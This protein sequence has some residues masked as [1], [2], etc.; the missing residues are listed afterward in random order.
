LANIERASAH[1]STTN[2]CE[3]DQFFALGVLL[4]KRVRSAWMTDVLFPSL[5]FPFVEF[6]RKYVRPA[7]VKRDVK[8]DLKPTLVAAGIKNAFMTSDWTFRV[9]G[10]PV[11]SFSTILRTKKRFC[12][13]QKRDSR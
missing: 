1:L 7:T 10:R 6:E 4:E 2:P 5:T 11:P 9:P 8:A 12:C 13:I 3:R